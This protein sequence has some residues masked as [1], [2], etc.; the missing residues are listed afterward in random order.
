[1][2]S[3]F[4]SC[5]SAMCSKERE[6][7]KNQPMSAQWFNSILAIAEI[8]KSNRIWPALH[9]IV[10]ISRDSEHIRGEKKQKR[11]KTKMPNDCFDVKTIQNMR[12][13]AHKNCFAFRIAREMFIDLYIRSSANFFSVNSLQAHRFYES[14]MNHVTGCCDQ[15]NEWMKAICGCCCWRWYCHRYCCFCRCRC[16]CFH[17]I[18]FWQTISPFFMARTQP[19]QL[20]WFFY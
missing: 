2:V 6:I 20:K 10:W 13:Y 18:A 16:C 4:K 7:A 3:T 15:L 11:W 12:N 9:L 5:K 17:L 1:M 14:T 19:N 8:C